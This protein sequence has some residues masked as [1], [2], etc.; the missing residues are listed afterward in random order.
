MDT[1]NAAVP[2][3]DPA[4]FR[5][6]AVPAET[7]AANDELRRKT[8]RGPNW[9]DVGPAAYR[10]AAAQGKGGFPRP[11][12]SKRAR[13]V[14]I[15]GRGGHRIPLHV[16]APEQPR[17]VYLHF[18]GGGMVFGAPDVQDPTL[19]RIA[20]RTGL[21]CASVGYRLAPEHPYP[22]AW[23]DAEDAALWAARHAKSQFGGDA[24][25][26]GGESAGATLSV[27]TLLRLRDRHGGV[28]F[29]AAV[30]TCGN[31]D[32]SMTPSQRLT[33]DEGIMGRTSLR[34]YVEAYL[35]PR[36]DPR[37]P[38]VSPLYA[39]LHG[40]PPAI[41]TVGTDDPLLDD[42]LFLYARWIA[43]ANPAE[44]AIYPGAAHGFTLLPVPEAGPANARIEEF[45]RAR[46]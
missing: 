19:E 28:P 13:T 7:R 5:P 10:A 26:I 24:L 29:R 3:L 31:F 12:Q 44:L 8:P 35:P 21:A 38:D 33:G 42:S 1:H 30:L 11:P 37:D 14:E 39:D 46:A 36:I 43:A 40:L 4:L 15:E 18:H 17:G 6:E 20:D 25:A 2:D 34:K 32:A 45:L 16:I 27:A 23:D 22:S 41:F 9:W